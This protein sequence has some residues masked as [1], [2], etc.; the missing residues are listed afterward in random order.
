MRRLLAFTA[1]L[2]IVLV[3]IIPALVVRFDFS[4]PA[5][6]GGGVIHKGEDVPIHVFIPELNKI[7]EMNLEDYVKGVVAAEMPAEFEFEALKAQAVAARTYAVKNMIAF[8]GPGL[9]EHPGADVSADHKQSQAWLSETQLKAK[10]GP[11]AYDR[12][13]SKIGK[14]VDATRGQ[15]ITYNGEPINAV[16]H[17]TSGERTASAKEVWGYDYP[18][19]QSVACTWDKAS[20]RYNEAKE[21]A[22]TEIEQRLGSDTGIMAAA[23]SGNAAVASII[24]LTDS[25]RVDKVRIGSKTLTG[26]A[27]RDKLELRST[28]FTVEHKGDKLIFKTIGY[29]HGVGLCQYGANGM[30]KEGRDYKRILTYYYTGVALKNIFGS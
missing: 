12:Y 26:Q 13:W 21:I 6:Q 2:V 11:F 23:Q 3:I 24:D 10:W 20:P 1:L 4:G 15:I 9:A 19:L 25:G 17:S 16:F 27:V 14:A 30:A 22:L 18:Y 28:S 5:L 29:G 7:V 8:G